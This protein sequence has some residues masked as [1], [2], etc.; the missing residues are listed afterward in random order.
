M[1]L[2]EGNANRLKN[3]KVNFKKLLK[4]HEKIDTIAMYQQEEYGFANDLVIQSV[5]NEDF[6]AQLEVDD[7]FLFKISSSVKKSD[8]KK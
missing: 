5:I 6:K 1:G 4:L 7:D 2:D 8:S 3:G